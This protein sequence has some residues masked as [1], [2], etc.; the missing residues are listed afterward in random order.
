MFGYV[1]WEVFLY[2][3]NSPTHAGPLA[4]NILGFP[5]QSADWSADSTP[6]SWDPNN[7]SAS[8]SSLASNVLLCE[9]PAERMK[10]SVPKRLAHYWNIL[11]THLALKDETKTRQDYWYDVRVFKFCET[12]N[13]DHVS[14]VSLNL[15]W[16]YSRTLRWN[17]IQ[18]CAVG[19]LCRPSPF[20]GPINGNPLK[21]AW[22]SHVHRGTHEVT[23]LVLSTIMIL[24]AKRYPLVS[25]NKWLCLK[26]GYLPTWYTHLRPTNPC[27][28]PCLGGIF[29]RKFSQDGITSRVFASRCERG[30]SGGCD[31]NGTPCW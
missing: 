23:C 18:I 11:G 1:G 4:R 30:T 15:P 8:A 5:R 21:K 24:I 17:Y 19:L 14:K 22:K 9:R 25:L 3:C 6:S 13:F 29:P 16:L 26:I 12:N 27:C 10:H 2:W 31:R 28:L 7:T 20:G